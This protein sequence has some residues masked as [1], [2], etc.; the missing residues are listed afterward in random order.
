MYQP[1]ISDRDNTEMFLIHSAI[2]TM[3]NVS[4]GDSESIFIDDAAGQQLRAMGISVNGKCTVV[5]P[6]VFVF[7]YDALIIS[8]G[9]STSITL[10]GQATAAVYQQALFALTYLNT[11]DEPTKDPP[12]RVEMQVYDGV[13]FSNVAVG[14]VNISLVNDNRLMFTCGGGLPTFVEESR[15]PLLVA[16]FLSI[17]DLDVNN[18]ITSATI[19]LDN[20]QIGDVIQVD[21]NASGG[22]SVEQASGVSI[23]INGQAMASQYQVSCNST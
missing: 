21:A 18:V 20:A 5:V 19:F 3:Y 15:T 8:A 11:A 17:F 1:V 16:S 23:R 2:V 4:D 6:C 13:F 22:L 14:F 9:T 12:R 7:S 10:T